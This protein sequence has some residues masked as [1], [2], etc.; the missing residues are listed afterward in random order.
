MGALVD[1]FRSKRVALCIALGFAAGLPYSMRGTTL[2]AWMTNAGVNLKTIGLYTWIGLFFTLKPLWAPLIDR[3][4]IPLL[5][6]RRGWMLATQFGLMMSIAGMGAI[7]PRLAP[8]ALAALVALTTFLTATQD[9]ASDA[10]RADMLRSNERASGS[11]MYTLGWRGATIVA[12]AG[13]LVL[14]D[15]VPWST[16]YPVMASLMVIGLIATWRGPEPEAVPTPRTVRDAVVAP[17]VDLFSRKGALVA[18]AFIM[19]YKFG[20]YMAADIITPFLIQTGFSNTEI[21]GVLKVMG[22]IA[23]IVGVVLGAGVVSLLGVRRSLLIFGIL[24][25]LMNVGYLALSIYGKSHILLVVA[26]AADWFCAGAAQA[27]F[28][29]YHLSLC[30]K[31]YSATQYAL[32]ASAATLL[33]RLVGGVSGFIIV[34][35][36]WPLFFVITM[37]VAIP[38]LLLILFGGLDRAVYQPP[39][40]TSRSARLN[41]RSPAEPRGP[42]AG[43]PAWGGLAVSRPGSR[44]RRS[45]RAWWLAPCCCAHRPRGTDNRRGSRR[46]PCSEAGSVAAPS[47]GAR[48][49]LTSRHSSCASHELAAAAGSHRRVRNCS[50]GKNRTQTASSGQEFSSHPSMV[51]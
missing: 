18:I 36:G 4:S 27:A 16:V 37:V 25:A 41:P 7:D 13:S 47:S 10:Y 24:Q 11:A 40:P 1:A 29:A 6:R 34:G 9:I 31:R 42:H 22:M 23:T 46:R 50:A 48:T 21:A 3:Y 49:S 38:G 26:I 20:D 44:I 28:S 2:S 39:P 30:S 33:G 14:S 17:L 8:V 43:L 51:Q 15:I 45:Y 5:G 19:L 32:I 35:V 12:G